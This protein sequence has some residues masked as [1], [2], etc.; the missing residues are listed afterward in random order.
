MRTRLFA[1]AA[2][3]VA[4]RQAMRVWAG[5]AWQDDAPDVE[6]VAREMVAVH[7]EDA[8]AFLLDQASIAEGIGDASSADTLRDIAGVATDLT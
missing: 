3:L 2:V 4:G 6:Q 8:V 7:G 5:M 1:I